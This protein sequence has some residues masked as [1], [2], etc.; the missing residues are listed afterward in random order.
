MNGELD[1]H[2]GYMGKFKVSQE[3]IDDIMKYLVEEQGVETLRD[4]ALK[5]VKEGKTTVDEFNKIIA[6]ID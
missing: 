6:Y 4:Q 5:L 1:V 2:S 3:E